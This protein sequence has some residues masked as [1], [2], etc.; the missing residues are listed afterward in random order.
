MNDLL[1]F[2]VAGS[3]SYNDES[4]CRTPMTLLG[5][6]TVTVLCPC[7]SPLQ[8]QDSWESDKIIKIMKQEEGLSSGQ[9]TG[10]RLRRCGFGSATDFLCAYLGEISKG[11]EHS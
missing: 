10:L 4:Q 6:H 5:L 11:T 2:T 8:D 3:S 1:A 7:N 9:G